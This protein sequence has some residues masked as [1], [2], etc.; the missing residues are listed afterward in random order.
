[1]RKSIHLTSDLNIDIP[2]F[3]DFGGKV[4]LFDKIIRE[5]T[6]FEPH[7]FIAEHWGVEVEIFDVDCHEFGTWSRDYAVEKKLDS[8]EID[9]G[10]ATVMWVV[11]SIAANSE[12]SAVGIV[13]F[14]PVVHNNTAVCDISPA[15][16]VDVRFVDEK[17]GVGAFNLA[18]HSLC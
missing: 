18:R 11:Y 13:F 7:I 17:D 8:E 6:E 5:V 14:W 4:V 16:S 2:I 3:G 9:S 10:S 12:T 1:M 15:C